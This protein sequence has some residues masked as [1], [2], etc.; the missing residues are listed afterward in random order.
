MVEKNKN[1]LQIATNHNFQSF[2]PFT[3]IIETLIKP[4]FPNFYIELSNHFISIIF[5]SE[6]IDKFI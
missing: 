2:K 4:F 6:K 1:S 3:C 5:K